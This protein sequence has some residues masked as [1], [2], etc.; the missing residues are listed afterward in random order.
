M[1][2]SFSYLLFQSNPDRERILYWKDG[3]K[4]KEF[5]KREDFLNLALTINE[6]KNYSAIF[7]A[8]NTYSFYLWDTLDQKVIHLTN[9]IEREEAYK[10]KNSLVEEINK[11]KFNPQYSSQQELE[12]MKN[13]QKNSTFSI[14]EEFGFEQPSFD[15]IPLLTSSLNNPSSSFFSKMKDF[16]K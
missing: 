13:P 14:L 15:M 4:T 10:Y 7:D 16:F 1:Y 2:I 12:R 11:V 6:G 9:K 8:C 3:S 5:L